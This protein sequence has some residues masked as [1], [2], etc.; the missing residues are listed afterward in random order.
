[1]GGY[2]ALRTPDRERST[3]AT[4]D[5]PRR[6][7]DEDDSPI[8]LARVA[9]FR[10]K[11]TRSQDESRDWS[12]DDDA[13]ELVDEFADEAPASSAFSLAAVGE[14]VRSRM[15]IGVLVLVAGLLGFM[16]GR[17]T[18]PDPP[19]EAAQAWGPA[20]PASAAP[21]APKWN[22]D[23]STSNATTWAAAPVLPKS[24]EV[25]LRD[26]SPIRDA[27]PAP[28]PWNPP[29]DGLPGLPGKSEEPAWS[30]TPPSEPGNLLGDQAIQQA[31][32]RDIPSRPAEQP[33]QQPVSQP[34]AGASQPPQWGFNQS[35]NLPSAQAEGRPANRP[36][37][38]PPPAFP[39]MASRP[40]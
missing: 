19:Q 39:Q 7:P 8:V 17:A 40:A 10:S 38:N 32:P 2:Q 14:V 36:A 25:P 3:T 28:T 35:M 18:S 23:S 5:L 24:S 9:N 31:L 6:H 26:E 11:R 37:E 30:R 34:S 33:P 16:L 13:D 15:A 22:S 20:P 1:M 27:S 29:A 4:Y 12:C 21:E